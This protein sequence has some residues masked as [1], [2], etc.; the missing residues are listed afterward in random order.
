MNTYKP[1]VTTQL[2]LATGALCYYTE[3]WIAGQSY[4]LELRFAPQKSRWKRR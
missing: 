2:V 3:I 4:K 1:T